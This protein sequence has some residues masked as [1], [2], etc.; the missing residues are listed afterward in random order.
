MKKLENFLI[1]GILGEQVGMG[2]GL[3]G[4]SGG[5]LM[6]PE[7]LQTP[8][9]ATNQIKDEDL[10]ASNWNWRN[11]TREENIE[12]G[13][14]VQKQR[15]MRG[16]VIDPTVRP[17]ADGLRTRPKSANYYSTKDRISGGPSAHAAAARNKAN[18]NLEQGKE[19]DANDLFYLQY[20]RE[21]SPGDIANM[22][23]QAGGSQQSYALPK[24]K[25]TDPNADP[26]LFDVSDKKISPAYWVT[27]QDFEKATGERYDARNP[28]HRQTF[29][30]L[31]SS[32]ESTVA[33]T[34]GVGQGPAYDSMAYHTMR[35]RP[36]NVPQFG[37]PGARYDRLDDGELAATTPQSRARAQ[38]AA[39][40]EEDRKKM[41]AGI[42]QRDAEIRTQAEK[43]VGGELAMDYFKKWADRD[44]EELNKQK[45]A[46]QNYIDQIGD[47][48]DNDGSRRIVDVDPSVKRPGDTQWDTQEKTPSMSW[49]EMEK[50]INRE[51]PGSAVGDAQNALVNAAGKLVSDKAKD[52]SDFLKKNLMTFNPYPKEERGA[53]P[54]I[55]R[56]QF[57]IYPEGQDDSSYEEPQKPQEVNVGPAKYTPGTYVVPE[58]DVWNN[59]SPEEQLAMT[60]AALQRGESHKFFGGRE[61]KKGGFLGIGGERTFR[62]SEDNSGQTPEETARLNRQAKMLNAL[63]DQNDAG[64]KADQAETKQ[65]P[66]SESGQAID[67]ARQLARMYASRLQGGDATGRRYS[68]A[69]T[70][71]LK[72]ETPAGTQQYLDQF[73]KNIG[74]P[75]V[76]QEWPGKRKYSPI[77]LKNQKSNITSE[78]PNRGDDLATTASQGNARQVQNLDQ[79]ALDSMFV[80]LYGNEMF[81]TLPAQQRNLMLM[82]VGRGRR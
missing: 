16:R 17:D 48:L 55:Q 20:Q 18:T 22:H 58:S 43:T 65:G 66:K 46:R 57:P 40:A 3:A 10:S 42:A 80:R 6:P 44:T 38:S 30:D 73:R 64:A 1:T 53:D 25:S 39:D 72:S 19:L 36:K 52:V 77:P 23:K 47:S 70:V 37:T 27:Y 5:Q 35:R 45:S 49:D 31:N 2:G 71:D 12:Q 28:K 21:F 7:L 32:G 59:M 15:D 63:L 24:A 69:P 54:D 61:A 26:T 76:N 60:Q 13:R 79:N 4:T 9:N 82:Q 62:F 75:V 29:F 41:E 51:G 11:H 34:A 14:K 67:S 78:S 50:E 81:H 56:G 68:K 8:Q 33:P 74:K